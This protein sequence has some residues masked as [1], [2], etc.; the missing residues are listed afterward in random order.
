M[1]P[2]AFGPVIVSA[3]FGVAGAILIESTLSF[4]GYGVLPPT[5]SWGQLLADAFENDGCWW[6]ALFPGLVLTATVLCVN[7]V[8]EGLREA[9]DPG[10]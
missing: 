3:T 1:L 4:L 5:A 8:G 2:G 7:L 10:E 9:V 6:L